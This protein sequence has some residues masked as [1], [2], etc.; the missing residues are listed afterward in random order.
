MKRKVRFVLG[1][2]ISLVFI[3]L[4]SGALAATLSV[5]TVLNSG[6]LPTPVAVSASDVFD[7]GGNEFV[8]VINSS[9]GTTCTFTTPATVEGVAVSDPAVALT[10][11]QS[12]MVGPFKTGIFNDANGR[13]TV[14]CSP[15]A[16]TT[17]EVWRL[18]R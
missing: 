15:T 6:V 12:K 11:G 7:N 2:F 8:R 10:A 4:G 9:G 16:N 3:F 17:I 5:V 14:A 1:L 18:P 13:V